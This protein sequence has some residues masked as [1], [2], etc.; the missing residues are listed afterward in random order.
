MGSLI[1]GDHVSLRDPGRYF[2]HDEAGFSMLKQD[3]PGV[4]L[5][6][7]QNCIVLVRF[8]TRARIAID[9]KHLEFVPRSAANDNV[10]AWVKA[11]T[12]RTAFGGPITRYLPT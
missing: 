7:L 9:H 3:E 5:E 1:E 12:K 8:G 10:P 4:V 6:I 2:H 11:K